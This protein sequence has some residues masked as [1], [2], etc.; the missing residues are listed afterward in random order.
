MTTEEQPAS[1]GE[2]APSPAA[3]PGDDAPVPVP[4]APAEPAPADEV[5]AVKQEIERTREQLGETVGQLAAKA[6]VKARA[7]AKVTALTGRVKAGTGQA[8]QQATARLIGAR[9][10]LSAK[11]TAA[12]Q[13]VPSSSGAGQGQLQAR[14]A[15]VAAPVWQ[16][17]PEPVRRTAAK[18][19]ST[20]KQH[21]MPLALAAG[22]LVAACLAA[23]WWRRAHLAAT[24]RGR[25]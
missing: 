12:R 15:A 5:E 2:T 7:R 24:L 18:G 8:R 10:Q 6:D 4:P 14:A 23:S 11:A 21:R 9:S 17:T 25:R 13:K 1:L 22:A 3:V 16:A 20:A 19:A